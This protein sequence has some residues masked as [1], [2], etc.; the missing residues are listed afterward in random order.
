MWKRLPNQDYFQLF[1]I[2]TPSCVRQDRFTAWC[3]VGVFLALGVLVGAFFL[4]RL[5]SLPPQEPVYAGKTADEWLNAGYEDAAQGLQHIGPSAVPFILA[6]LS[7]EDPRYGSQN[8]Y[9]QFWNKVPLPVRR[10]L[11]QPKGGAFDEL[12]ACNLL[13]ELGPG[14]IPLLCT[15][16]R[17]YNPVVREVSAHALGSFRRQ[18]R[19]IAKAVPLL[20]ETSRDAV[21]EVRVRAAWALSQM[22]AT[23][24][25]S[26]P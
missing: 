23:D 18:G 24:P 4:G 14:I 22:S 16:L 3:W 25:N 7:R 6:K 13:L 1:A 17:D 8:H 11:P 19:D 15:G 21:P 26:S 2:D 20:R 12:H 5:L 10:F 9:R